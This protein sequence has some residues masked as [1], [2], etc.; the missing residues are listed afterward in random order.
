MTPIP[1]PRHV[2]VVVVHSGQ[3][4]ALAGSHYAAR[5]LEC[6]RAQ[7]I[8]GPLR[9]ATL[10]DVEGLE[11]PV[12]RSRARHVIGENARVRAFADALWAGDLERCG[13]LMAMSHRSLAADFEVS[14]NALDQLVARLV[15]RPGVFGARLTGAGFGGCVVALTKPGAIAEGFHVTA[16][17][18]ARTI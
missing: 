16:S 11:D 10:D 13:E 9:S 3:A 17:A 5:R 7:S 15:A 8:I 14:T 6:E 4:R 2:D 1:L 18:G 12:L